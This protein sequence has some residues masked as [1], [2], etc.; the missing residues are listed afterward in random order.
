MFF[1]FVIG[2]FLRKSAIFIPKILILNNF[3]IILQTENYTLAKTLLPM[4]RK[5]LFLALLFVGLV[6]CTYNTL[7][8]DVAVPIVGEEQG[9]DLTISTRAEVFDG[10][11]LDSEYFVAE[12]DLESYLGYKQKHSGKR[13][14]VKDCTPYG[15]DGSHTLF[16]VLNY[17]DGWEVVSADKRTQATLAYGNGER[18]FSMGADNTNEAEKFWMQL[19]AS[20]VLQ[21]RQRTRSARD[22]NSSELVI[23]DDEQSNVAFWNKVCNTLNST[24]VIEVSS[25]SQLP[26]G[27]YNVGATADTLI[28]EQGPFTKTKWNQNFP[29]NGYSPLKSNSDSVRAPAGCVAVALGQLLYY[30]QDDS[31]W[32]QCH[33]PISATI[34]GNVYNYNISFSQTYSAAI[35]SAMALT[36]DEYNNNDEFDP[37]S[38]TSLVGL[39]L[40]W[41][42]NKVDMQYG[43]SVS[44]A[45][46]ANSIAWAKNEFGMDYQ[47][48]DGYSTSIVIEELKEKQTPIYVSAGRQTG[49]YTVGRHAFLLD[50]FM[51]EKIADTVHYVAAPLSATPEELA[52]YTIE[53]TTHI[54]V[55][56]TENYFV[57]MNWGW[58][59]IKDGY[60]SILNSK[61]NPNGTPYNVAVSLF[62]DF[63]L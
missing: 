35:W 48:Y 55:Y 18:T 40:A 3:C 10:Q 17:A 43:D 50:G 15:F 33:I 2:Y 46:S 26:P 59:G 49:P 54:I 47:R 45:N 12:E 13:I 27:S 60:Y 61:W 22:I 20:D 25:N 8:D 32:W 58:G 36:T 11:Q 5:L 7:P 28:I 44:G 53:D 41:I 29:W 63:E 23:D 16:Y 52:Q 6:G 1:V 34:S 31:G 21:K 42:G 51:T 9:F 39:L 56:K 57:H 38:P 30:L 4:K 19:L 24:R 14:T 62:Y 37:N